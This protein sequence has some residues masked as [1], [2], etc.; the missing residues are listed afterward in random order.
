MSLGTICTR[1][2]QKFHHIPQLAE[3]NKLHVETCQLY[4]EI[5]KLYVENSIQEKPIE[6]T[7]KETKRVTKDLKLLLL[8][9][10]I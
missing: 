2:I 6:V 9:R 8:I 5:S 7:N 1:K 3:N 10:K 4:A